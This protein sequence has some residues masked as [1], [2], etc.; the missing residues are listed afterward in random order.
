MVFQ[1]V[2]WRGINW[3]DMARDRQKCWALANTVMNLRVPDKN[4]LTSLQLVCFSGRTFLMEL[5]GFLVLIYCLL[6]VHEFFM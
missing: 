5:Y 3:I 1:E 4:F 2:E 6:R